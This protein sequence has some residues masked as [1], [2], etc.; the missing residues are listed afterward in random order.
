MKIKEFLALSSLVV[1]LGIA[2]LAAD[3]LDPTLLSKSSINQPIDFAIS[4]ELPDSGS[5]NNEP[6][7]QGWLDG[8]ETV[9][10]SKKVVINSGGYYPDSNYPSGIYYGYPEGYSGSN[11]PLSWKIGESELGL[12]IAGGSDKHASDNRLKYSEVKAGEN[13]NLVVYSPKGGETDVYDF[14]RSDSELS[15][16]VSKITVPAGESAGQYK[17]SLVGRHF[18]FLGAENDVSN[19]VILDVVRP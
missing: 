17:A 3:G 6:I 4:N 1:L 16:S 5:T 7:D 11:L 10:A 13:I 2:P 9:P 19:A 8:S 14:R 12:W 15:G 18:L